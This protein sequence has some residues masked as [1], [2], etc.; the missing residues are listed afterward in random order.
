[1]D[2]KAWPLWVRVVM[3]SA[4]V[5]APFVLAVAVRSGSVGEALVYGAFLFAMW[6]GI[7]AYA[8]RPG[9]RGRH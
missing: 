9:R 8:Q 2:V 1:V 4:I 3:A 7:I 5:S 6:L